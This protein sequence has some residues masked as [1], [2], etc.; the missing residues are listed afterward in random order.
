MTTGPSS[1]QAT[2][3][4][5]LAYFASTGL[6]TTLLP[7]VLWAKWKQQ[8]SERVTLGAIEEAAKLSGIDLTPDEQRAMLEGLNENLTRYEELR[9]VHIENSVPL[10]LH[11]DP[12]VAGE[13][14]EARERVFRPSPTPQVERPGA[15]EEV[16][17]WP[18]TH[19]AELVRTRQVSAL[20]LAEMYLSRLERHNER[21]NCVVTLTRDLAMS[22]ARRADAELAAGRYLGPLHGIPWGAKDIISAR[23]YPTTWGVAPFREQVLDLDA[24][25]VERLS[26]AGA[27]LVAKLTTGELAFGDRWFGGRTMSPWDPEEGSS[28]SS[29]GSGA[30]TAAGLVGFAIGTDTGG[31]ILAPSVRCGIVGLRPTFGRVSR[32]GVMAAGFS[33]DR[34][35]PMCRT[36]E[37][38]ALVLDAIA[39]PDGR[40]LSVVENRPVH[41]NANADA[42]TLRVGYTK[43]LFDAEP[44]GEIRANN[45]ATLNEMRSL[46]ID[47]RPVSLPKSDINFFIEYVERGAGFDEFART[48]LDAGLVRQR[49]RAELRVARFVPAVEYLQANRARYLLMQEVARAMADLDVIVAPRPT[50]DPETSVNPITSLT[51]HPSVA[52]PNGFNS[53]GTPTGMCLVGRLYREG[54]MLL[55]A[56]T[57]Q[58]RT[59]FHE[60]RPRSFER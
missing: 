44:D 59:R 42:S 40:D 12:R 28:G 51:G 16:A 37:D 2:R 18:V 32:Y 48:R 25:V 1:N 6:S 33:L 54:E 52:V 38:C 34:V 47:P 22:Q 9:E 8:G 36:A 29:A 57:Y 14:P 49:H 60:R 55:L 10:P 56:K 46:G 20:E 15:L 11:F 21:L 27:V 58:D 23:G 53:R 45:E 24:A 7:G 41:W 3:R 30:A 19:L 17:F 50:L 13:I 26:Q 39:G 4:H 5:F 35:G 43:E 31:S